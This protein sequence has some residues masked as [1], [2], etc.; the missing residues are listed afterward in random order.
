MLA[1]V[2]IVLCSA[3]KGG[4]FME[5]EQ[6]NWKELFQKYLPYLLVGFIFLCIG[7]SMIGPFF[8]IRL[9]DNGVKTDTTYYLVKLLFSNDNGLPLQLFFL[10]I[11]L[12]FPIVGCL[13][14]LI[15]KKHRNLYVIAILLFI[16]S[17]IT[18]ILSNDIFAQSLMYKT[19]LDYSTHG[20]SF[21][22]VLPIVAFFIASFASLGIAFS[23]IAF[24]IQDLTETGIL[25]G[26]A[27]VLNFI[28]IPIGN[29]GGSINF[30]VIP[31][32][33]LALRKGPIKGF[34]GAGIAYG[35]ISCLTDGYGIATYPFDYLVG[36]GSCCLLGF[37]TK[38]IFGEEQNT[39]NIKGEVFL[40]VG[41]LICTLVRF[42]GSSASS[43]IIYAYDLKSALAYNAIYIPIS[44]AISIAVLMA[45]YGTFLKINKRFSVK[46]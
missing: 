21:C 15:G 35:L 44:G 22:F 33:I 4:F 13:F 36:L 11:Y 9:K 19:E 5:K 39:Y 27:L 45:I 46:Q 41:A 43:M 16:L 1:E 23:K 26:L 42:I 32:F 38:Y 24:T 20:V 34:V 10:F 2:R 14:I 37:F 28:K 29:T 8:E 25:V 30:Q 31:L 17:G 3:T 7:L 6:K 18:A 40:L 12:I